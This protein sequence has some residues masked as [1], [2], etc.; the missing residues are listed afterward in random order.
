M[1]DVHVVATPNRHLYESV[2]V[3]YH[4]RRCD[5]FVRERGWRHLRIVDDMEFDEYDDAHAIHL[6]MTD[7]GRVV[8]GQRLYPACLPHM[9]VDVF[10]HLVQWPLPRGPRAFECS[11][12][13]IVPERRGGPA[14]AR[15]LLA[16]QQFCVEEGIETLSGVS[17]LSNLSRRL[18]AGIRFR[19]LGMPQDIDGQPT[20]AVVADVT[21]QS[22][23]ASMRLLG[24]RR[25]PLVRR[26][27]ERGFV[28]SCRY[29]A[30]AA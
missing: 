20:I 21:P 12:Y 2:L 28:A 4:R 24:T 27:I 8:G 22:F 19:P 23:E 1:L 15:L 11:R 16:M 29:D 26:G 17:E 6:V 30:V 10:A 13:F 14:D 25:L 7:R 5:V 9:M 3:D 18:Q